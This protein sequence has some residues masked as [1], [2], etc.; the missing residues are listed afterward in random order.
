MMSRRVG[1]VLM[2]VLVL[3]LTVACEGGTSGS[4]SGSSERCSHK[5]SGGTCSGKFKR[6]R[7]TYTKNVES[8][9]IFSGSAIPVEVKAS[10][11]SG[12]LRVYVEDPDGEVTSVDVAPG[13]TGTLV[14]FAKGEFD[15]FDVKF[16]AVGEE[17][18]GVSWEIVY[19]IP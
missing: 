15:E 7:G 12:T 17:A 4:V 18:T 11:E 2:M 13:G 8:E 10:V 9:R 5:V 1:L 14:G 3:V 16:E 19:Q 6:L